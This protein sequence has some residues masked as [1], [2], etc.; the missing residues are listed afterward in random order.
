MF[1]YHV[2]D[3]R[4]WGESGKDTFFDESMEQKKK[5]MHEK[6]ISLT[7]DVSVEKVGTNTHKQELWGIQWF[8]FIF[9]LCW[10]CLHRP[11]TSSPHT[12]GEGWIMWE[13][14]GEYYNFALCRSGC[15]WA[16]SV[17]STLC[18]ATCHTSSINTVTASIIVT[19]NASNL[20][21]TSKSTETVSVDF[22]TSVWKNI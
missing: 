18:T 4:H 16:H 2:W 19:K 21:K 7:L 13:E 20:Q 9:S 3:G 10:V 6:H 12:D 22:Q 17:C 14:F 15:V 8:F 11:V 1:V 5:W